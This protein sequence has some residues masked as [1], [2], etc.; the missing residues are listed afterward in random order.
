MWSHAGWIVLTAILVMMTER[1]GELIGT[2]CAASSTT[3]TKKIHDVMLGQ[4]IQ[5][6]E[7]KFVKLADNRWMAAE[8]ANLCPDPVLA[9]AGAV[10]KFDYTGDQQTFTAYAGC[11]Y[12]LEVWG[13]QGGTAVNTTSGYHGGYGGYSTGVID[14][15]KQEVIYIVVGGSGA[16]SPYYEVN[17]YGVGK[18]ADGGYN[19]GGAT[20]C[21]CGGAV[22][23][24]GGASHI[25]LTSGLLATLS[26]NQKDILIVAGGGGGNGNYTP[27]SL[28][29]TGGSGGGVEGTAGTQGHSTWGYGRGGTQNSGGSAVPASYAGRVGEAGGF[30]YGADSVYSHAGGAAGGGGLYGGASGGCIG[31]GGGGSGYIGSTNLISSNGIIKHMTCYN[32]TTSTADATRTQSN[33][34]VNATET[35]DCSKTGNGYARITR[36]N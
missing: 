28:Y 6:G 25:A 21:N 11:Q 1:Q 27:Q 15:S 35:A 24:G 26:K 36:L 5:V 14:V 22:S 31:S 18:C 8:I 12:K 17:G 29:T 16:S 4:E 13:A 7:S 3:S 9:Y 33:T 32:C 2:V 30:G 10:K 19:G 20:Y 34:C 23:S